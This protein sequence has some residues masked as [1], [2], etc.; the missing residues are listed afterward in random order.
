MDLGCYPVH[1]IRAFMQEEPNVTGAVATLNPLGADMSMDAHL[2]FSSG[3]TGRITAS[4]HAEAQ[5]GSTLV[6]TGS[7]GALRVENLVFP[8]AGHSITSTID[9]V[10]RTWTVRG[11][12]T[13]DHQLDALVQALNSGSPMPT[14]GSDSVLNMTVIDAI[15]AAAKI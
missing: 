8:S 4:M 15:Y 12:V 5:A 10:S 13:Y 2:G 3:A 6:I 7:T 9:G 1:W 14:E 11:D